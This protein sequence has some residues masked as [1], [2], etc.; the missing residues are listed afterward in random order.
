MSELHLGFGLRLR[1]CRVTW[2]SIY[3]VGRVE[4]WPMPLGND[5]PGLLSVPDLLLGPLP[6]WFLLK[7]V[8]EGKCFVR[9]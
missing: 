9:H 3:G 5:A 7:G 1:S 4:S 2:K 6:S 8:L